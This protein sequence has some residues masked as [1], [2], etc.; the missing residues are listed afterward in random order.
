[1]KKKLRHSETELEKLSENEED[2][3]LNVIENAAKNIKGVKLE[4]IFRMISNSPDVSKKGTTYHKL[5]N[6]DFERVKKTIIIGN[7]SEFVPPAKKES[8]DAYTHKWMA[9]VRGPK[10]EP[11]ISTYVKFI[12]FHL[13]PSYAPMAD[14]DVTSPPFHLSKRGWSGFP[15]RVELHFASEE[16]DDELDDDE[17]THEFIYNNPIELVHPLYLDASKCGNEILGPETVVEL[18]LLAVK[19]VK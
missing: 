17:E 6:Y 5:K 9:Y 10:E 7:T 19:K 4:D 3:E 14:I 13:D 11:D 16:G 1:M 8:H 2:E 18:E 12:T 15:L